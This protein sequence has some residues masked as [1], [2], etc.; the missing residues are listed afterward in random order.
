MAATCAATAVT[1]L[2]GFLVAKSMSLGVGFW[3]V[4]SAMAAGSIASLL[5]VSVAG[6]GT[7][8]ATLALFLG[9]R[10]IGMPQILGF[11]VA[12]LFVTNGGTALLGALAW[13]FKPSGGVP[14]TG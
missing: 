4:S 1:F 13:T 2:Q 10:H 9:T 11:S 5:P 14:Q 7:R 6:L 8:E 3:A 12:V